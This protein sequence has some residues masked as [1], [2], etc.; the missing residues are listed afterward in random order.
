MLTPPSSS[1][2]SLRLRGSGRLDLLGVNSTQEDIGFLLTS[3]VLM[4]AWF[5]KAA[6]R[7]LTTVEPAVP[8]RRR[9]DRRHRYEVVARLQGHPSIRQQS[10]GSM[11]TSSSSAG[12][13]HPV[14]RDPPTSS[15]RSGRCSQLTVGGSLLSIVGSRFVGTRLPA[16]IIDGPAARSPNRP[17]G[18]GGGPTT[19]TVKNRIRLSVIL[20]IILL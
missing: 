11:G 10:I 6:G 3:W 19:G 13:R 7:A 18:T 5:A 14:H 2:S 9:R 12:S 1:S 17:K 8:R 20:L 16:G 15:L 4:S